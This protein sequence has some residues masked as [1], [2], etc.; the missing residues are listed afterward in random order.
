[1]DDEPITA[2]WLEAVG[3][4]FSSL[5]ASRLLPMPAG[6]DDGAIVEMRLLPLNDKEEWCVMLAQ[7]LPH[8]DDQTGEDDVVV[9]TS[10]YPRTRSEL[11]LLC[12]GLGAPLEYAQ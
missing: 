6:L 7:G 12:Q 8:G 1:M 11:S 3:F 4:S 2:D 5:Y 9:I 10:V